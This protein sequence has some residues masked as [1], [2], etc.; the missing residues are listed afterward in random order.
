MRYLAHLLFSTH[1]HRRGGGRQYIMQREGKRK[2]VGAHETQEFPPAVTL[3]HHSTVTAHL[4]FSFWPSRPYNIQ[5]ASSWL[6]KYLEIFPGCG[7]HARWICLMN[8]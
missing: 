2:S 5:S 7:Q 4:A 3:W 6:Q 8:K 1:V